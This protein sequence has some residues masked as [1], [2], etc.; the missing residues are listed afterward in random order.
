MRDEKTEDYLTDGGYAWRFVKDYD[1]ARINLIA[2]AA[3]PARLGR[4]KDDERIERMAL[5]LIEGKSFPAIV[6][7]ANEGE[8]YD[9]LVTG[10]HRGHAARTAELSMFDAYVIVCGDP[11]RRA[12]LP[13]SINSIEGTASTQSQDL[14]QI[15]ELLRLF[16]DA[17]HTDLAQAFSLKEPA[18]SD[19]LKLIELEER[20]ER[21]GVGEAW[22]RI[23][24]QGIRIKLGRIGN[25][26]VFAMAVHTIEQ[27][28]MV[29]KPA[30]QLIDAVRKARTEKAAIDV[31]Q[32]ALRTFVQ[33]QEQA[34]AKFGKRGKQPVCGRWFGVLRRLW[35]FMPV[36]DVRK[37]HLDAMEATSVTM[38]IL[39]LKEVRNQV[40][41]VLADQ[42]RR[43][44]QIEKESAW[45]SQIRTG[46]PQTA[47]ISASA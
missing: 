5:K 44:E 10:F 33:Q 17:K 30:E 13:R 3:N 34:K 45:R 21:L 6:V 43:L 1:L 4:R 14:A 9:S 24:A 8:D 15:A 41:D 40:D 2:E 47:G 32:D 31:L 42:E 28:K 12:L 37:L 16:P 27:T 18:I 46:V 22:G 26:N 20:A 23:T 11:Y 35:R 19:Y 36:W 7:F 29:G 38:N 25:D 39:M